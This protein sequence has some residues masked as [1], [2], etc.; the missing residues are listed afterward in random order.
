MIE[1]YGEVNHISAIY[2]SG[3]DRKVSE[4]YIS[5]VKYFEKPIYPLDACR[6]KRYIMGHDEEEPL[7]QPRV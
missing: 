4:D 3:V 1:T 7:S 2:S 6:T 5:S